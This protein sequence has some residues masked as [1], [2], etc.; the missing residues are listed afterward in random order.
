MNIKDINNWN[1]A[2]GLSKTL[3][4]NFVIGIV[5]LLIM[6]NVFLV[7]ALIKSNEKRISKIEQI[8]EE[9]KKERG[10]ADSLNRQ[11]WKQYYLIKTRSER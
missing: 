3:L 2:Y 7:R 10:R 4:K 9:L 11:M 5:V 6:S 1:N 8:N